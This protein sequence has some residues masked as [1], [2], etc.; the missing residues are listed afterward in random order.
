MLTATCN[1][2]G[3]GFRAAFLFVLVTGAVVIMAA[4]VIQVWSGHDT[5]VHG[6]DA[7]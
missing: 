2:N 3:S 4:T 6:A 1:N 5:R 7:A